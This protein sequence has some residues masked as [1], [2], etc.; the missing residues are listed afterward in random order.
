MTSVSNK[1]YW[2]VKAAHLARGGAQALA[3][4]VLSAAVVGG[5]LGASLGRPI[6]FSYSVDTLRVSPRA[7]TN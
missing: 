7:R 3:G 5:E 4:R 1:V 2:S 6:H